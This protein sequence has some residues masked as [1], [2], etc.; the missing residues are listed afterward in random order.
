VCGV[1][2][3]VYAAAES[4]KT[5]FTGT[6]IF[7]ECSLE[8]TMPRME[9][10]KP[11]GIGDI[12]WH[13]KALVERIAF[14]GLLESEPAGTFEKGLNGHGGPFDPDENN[15]DSVIRNKEKLYIYDKQPNSNPPKYGEHS[16]YYLPENEAKRKAELTKEHIGFLWHD[17]VTPKD[18]Q[19]TTGFDITPE[20]EPLIKNAGV[21]YASWNIN[22]ATMKDGMYTQDV[23]VR[24]KFFNHTRLEA[25]L[26]K[27][28]RIALRDQ[29]KKYREDITDNTYELLASQ[30]LEEVV[31]E[32]LTL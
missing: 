8:G 15:A 17:L 24:P 32:K 20:F 16:K 23:F 13:A 1:D 29:I 12:A 5:T 27:T 10:M 19:G 6:G 3:K 9:L 22:G 25:Y 31:F 2:K 30:I 28:N 11:G 18:V 21:N 14:L 26:T 4:V 7:Q